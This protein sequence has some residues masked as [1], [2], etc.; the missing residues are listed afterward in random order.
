MDSEAEST[1]AGV[2]ASARGGSINAE[3]TTSGSVTVGGSCRDIQVL[4]NSNDQYVV[5]N[6]IA[7]D[8][9]EGRRQDACHPENC[10]VRTMGEACLE[11]TPA[12]QPI[13][14]PET[15]SLC[16]GSV[17]PSSRLSDVNEAAA[18]RVD[19][20]AARPCASAPDLLGLLAGVTALTCWL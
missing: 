9:C 19:T 4:D 11:S 8:A 3:R 17:A 14:A 13:G 16:Q 2:S 1:S 5:V 7:M 6:V 12:C 10:G 18:T 20:A 15:V